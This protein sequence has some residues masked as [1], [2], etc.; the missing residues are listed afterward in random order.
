MGIE[1]S[2]G[3][4]KIVERLDLDKGGWENIFPRGE[5]KMVDLYTDPIALAK[6]IQKEV[7]PNNPKMSWNYFIEVASRILQW[8]DWDDVVFINDSSCDEYHGIKVTEDRF[9]PRLFNKEEK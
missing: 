6:R 7:Y 8:C 5:F 9:V 2:L 4:K 1:F 3:K